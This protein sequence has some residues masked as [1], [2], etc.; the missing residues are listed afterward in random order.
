M[1]ILSSYGELALP[2]K[3]M[4]F[5]LDLVIERI[6][7]LGDPL[8]VERLRHRVLTQKENPEETPK[9]SRREACAT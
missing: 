1:F 5:E 4:D 8:D 2:R 6:E 3:S 7:F 9:E